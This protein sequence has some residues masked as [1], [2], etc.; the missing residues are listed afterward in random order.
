[1]GVVA[2]EF[3]PP[4]MPGAVRS[5]ATAGPNVARAR[6]PARR[7]G[8]PARPHVKLYGYSTEPV[9]RELALVQQQLADVGI[10]ATL[11]LGEAVGYTSMAERHVEPHR[12]RA[13]RVD[14]RLHRS[15]QL[16]RHALE[17]P[18]HP[19]TN[20]NNLSLFDD[21]TVNALDRARPWPTP[22]TRARRGVWRRVDERVMD[23]APVVPLIHTLRESRS[24][25]S[26]S[27][28]GTGTSTRIL[29]ID[30]LYLKRPLGEAA[31]P[32]PRRRGGA[33]DDAAVPAALRA[34]PLGRRSGSR[35]SSLLHARGG[36][37]AVARG[38]RAPPVGRPRAASWTGRGRRPPREVV[39]DDGAAARAHPR[40]PAGRRRARARRAVAAA[41]RRARLAARVD[42]RHAARAR[43]SGSW[44]GCSPATTAGAVDTLVSRFVDAMMAIPVLLLAIALASVLPRRQGVDHGAGSWGS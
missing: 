38:A 23:L 36:G 8:L 31:P 33:R 21:P 43:C 18:A 12:V 6:R 28:A 41:L 4:G 27:A 26:A 40:L 17:R 34:R 10:D 22:T 9:P 11:D 20:N 42:A 29:K 19:A 5:A 14:R 25:R 39:S 30:R 35:S 2:G 13:L 32:W 16:L 1:M 15:V 7:G 37:R 3:L 44:P 24:T